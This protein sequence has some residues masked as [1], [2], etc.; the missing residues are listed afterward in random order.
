MIVVGRIFNRRK[1]ADEN[2]KRGQE[3][4]TQ[5]LAKILFPARPNKKNVGEPKPDSFRRR[6]KV[7]P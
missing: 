4:Q 7:G 3:Q 1:T 2:Q 6:M 5:G